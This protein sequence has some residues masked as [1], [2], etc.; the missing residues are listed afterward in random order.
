MKF[1]RIK[2]DSEFQV[3]VQNK[4]DADDPYVAVDY[5]EWVA[6]GRE[7]EENAKFAKKRK[8]SISS[9][10][11]STGAFD[12]ACDDCGGGGAHAQMLASAMD[13]S[14]ATSPPGNIFHRFNI[15]DLQRWDLIAQAS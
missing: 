5:D 10:G 15:I 13:A 8:N 14:S 2:P 6:A 12:E 9:S 7:E 1:V 11:Y 3:R 4:G